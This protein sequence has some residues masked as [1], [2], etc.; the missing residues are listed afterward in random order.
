MSHIRHL[1]LALRTI[2]LRR[3]YNASLLYLSFFYS[4]AIRKPV[5]WGLPLS[6]SIEPTTSCNLR[7]PECPS[8]LRSFTRDRGNLKQ[9][10]FQTIIDQIHKFTWSINFY[11]Q[12]E[13]FINPDFLEMV[14]YAKSK[15]L[16]TSSSTNGHFLDERNCRKTISSGLDELIIS[17]DGL[18]QE[19]YS[20]YRKEGQ[21]NK[22]L[23]GTRSLIKMRDDLGSKH[24]KV[25][26]QFL[27]VKPNEHEIPQLKQLV[28]ELSVDELRIK[29][30]QVYD[31]K[32]GNPLIP[33]NEKYARYIRNED[34]S[35]RLKYKLKNQCWKM[36]H[37]CVITW[38]G[39]VVPCC[40][41]KDATMIQG[42][43]SEVDFR[44]IW[45]SKSYHKLRERIFIDRKSIEI[46]QNCTEGC[47]VFA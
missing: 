31:Y 32:N 37:S 47:Q 10:L 14:T 34:G 9:P 42:D 5:H 6:V 36:W 29:T 24:P 26:F 39:L 30:A 27:A 11:F 13:P 25:I 35:Y 41:D 20:A 15:R 12:G 17:I 22:V 44:N 33:E 2:T 38:N 16:Y 3:V 4:R 19:T 7:C 18:T 1:Q 45:R 40:F 46:C 21:L 8:G 28:R 23:D 43:V